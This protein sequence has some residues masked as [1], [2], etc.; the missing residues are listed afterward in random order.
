MQARHLDLI[1]EAFVDAEAGKHDRI[2]LFM[3]PRRGK[4]RRAAR[5]GALWWLARHPDHQVVIASYAADLAEGHGGWIRDQV[6]GTSGL[7]LQLRG[8]SRARDRLEFVG[9]EGGLIAVGVGGGLTGKGADLLIVDDPVKDR[10]DADSPTIRKATWDWWTDVATTRLHP[11]AV[12]ILI[13]TRWHEDD[14]GGRILAQEPDEWHV[15]RLPEFAEKDD[16]LGRPLDEPLWPQRYDKAA[17]ERTRKAIG[18]RSWSA[19]YQ[20]RPTAIE[21]AVFKRPWLR[22]CLPAAM[23]PPTAWRTLTVVGVDP[24]GTDEADSDDTGIVVAARG[25]AWYEGH[26]V[27]RVWVLDDRTVHATPAGWGE[28]ACIAAIDHGADVIVVERNNGGKMA[29]FV[30]RAAWRELVRKGL[31]RGRMMPAIRDVHV[32]DNKTLRAEPVAVWYEAGTVWHVGELAELEDQMTTWTGSGDSP[33][34]LDALVIACMQM[35]APVQED[36]KVLVGQRW[37]ARPGRR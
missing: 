32:R 23:E 34:R 28:A 14:L 27:D 9:H 31:T 16:P 25:G 10:R 17:G 37:A 20:Q 3:P 33:D 36:K 21:G 19:L 4:S 2:A 15:L 5:W 18:S 8:G 1:D 12:V 29:T 13:Q 35:I 11:G 30:I 24:A 7:G 6:A 26:L 22:R